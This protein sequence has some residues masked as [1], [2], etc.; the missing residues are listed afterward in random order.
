MISYI[1]LQTNISYY[2]KLGV[3]SVASIGKYIDLKRRE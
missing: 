1:I 2:E 3:A